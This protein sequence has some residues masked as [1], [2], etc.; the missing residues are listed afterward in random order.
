MKR[1]AV[2]V[3]VALGLILLLTAGFFGLH[4]LERFIPSKVQADIGE[5]LKVQDDEVALYLNEV[6]EEKKGLYLQEQTYLPIEWVN[7]KLNERFYWDSNEKLL[8]YALP[9]S[10]VYADHTTMG[11]A[12]KPLIWVNENGVYLSIG[13]VANYTDIRLTAYDT[14]EHK[15]V[16]IS[17]IWDEEEKAVVAREGKV[18]VKG[19]IKSPVITE[20][21]PGEQVTVLESMEKWKKIRTGDGF[22]GYVENKRLGEITK[23]VPVSSFE[24]PVYKSISL[25][26]P[27]TLA[28]HQ[29]T[30]PEGNSSFDRVIANTKGVNVISP[31]WFELTDNEG[32]FNSFADADYVKKAHDKGLQVWALLNNLND[33]VNTEILMSK[34]STRRKLIDSL[35]AEVERY[36]LDGINLDIES[37]KQEAGVHYVQFIRELSI[38][39]REKGIVL[40]VDN[41]VPYPGNEFY[42]LREQGIVADYVILMSYDEH[43]PGGDA[44]SV[45]SIGFVEDAIRDTLAYDVPKEKII[46]GIPFFT[47]VW[48]E[49]SSGEVSASALGI[50]AA[51]EWVS[52]NQAELYWQEELGQYYGEIKTKAG[53]KKLWMEEE[54]SIGLKM[55][56]IKKYDLAGVAC[57]KLGFEPAQ[58]WDIVDLNQE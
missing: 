54:K 58:L 37:I 43:Y 33:N 32:N 1:R 44:G 31:T 39:C 46:N 57:W 11:S 5:L 45:A 17:N 22:I 14:S 40:S 2:P 42:N 19:G 27:V 50:S 55:D 12:G 23:E 9:D 21:N 20:V 41:H 49:A 24:A 48:T 7:E 8:V 16:F 10:V 4:F 35:M 30:S 26:E 13:L 52:K 6:L 28:W 51:K 15:R 3:L 47:R 36:G 56:L 38:P 34:T 25:G 53:V 18:R 29:V